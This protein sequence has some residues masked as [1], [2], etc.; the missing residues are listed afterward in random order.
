M[1]NLCRMTPKNDLEVYIRRNLP[2]LYLPKAPAKPFV[3]ALDAGMFL[4]S[5]GDGELHGILGQLVLI[6]PGAPARRD[7]MVPKAA[8]GRQPPAPRA[9]ST[10][11]AR[12]EAVATSPNFRAAWNE[13][14][15]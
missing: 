8:P 3:G 11:N 12:A 9:K 14:R 10:N 6:R 15:R 5:D 13:G 4:H 7:M 2:R 1:C